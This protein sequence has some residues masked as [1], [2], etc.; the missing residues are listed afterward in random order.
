MRLLNRIIGVFGVALVPRKSVKSLIEYSNALEVYRP[1]GPPGAAW[2]RRCARV[3]PL[4]DT[5]RNSRTVRDFL[6]GAS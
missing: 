4:Y 1:V 5:D 6:G 3:M 2:I